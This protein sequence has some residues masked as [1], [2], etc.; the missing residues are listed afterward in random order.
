M[1]KLEILA[2]PFEDKDLCRFTLAETLV[3]SGSFSIRK[4]VKTDSKLVNKVFEIE[5]LSEVTAESNYLIV[6]KNS[7]QTWRDLGPK[8]GAALRVAH[9]EGYLSFPSEVSTSNSSEGPKVNEE[10]FKTELGKKICQTIELKISPSLGAHGG[11][12]VPVDFKE[13]VLYL[14]FSGGCQGCSQASVT[15]RDGILRVLKNEFHEVKE[16][17]DITDHGQGTNPYYK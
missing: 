13:G 1:K 12:V 16:V 7:D 9:T 14:S 3:E 2:T 6:R 15:V 11:S 5:G 17:V 10:F 4:G 8:V